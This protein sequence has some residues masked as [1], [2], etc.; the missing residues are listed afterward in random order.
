MKIL[1]AEDDI[2]LGEAI[3]AGLHYEGICVDWFKRGD[4]A[5]DALSLSD[6]DGFIL[7]IGLPGRNGLKV[8]ENLRRSG[9]HTP[10]LILTAMG[11]IEDRVNG[12]DQ[13]ADD[14]LVKPFD[15]DELLA[16]LRALT[17][18]SIGR[19]E[20]TIHYQDITITPAARRVEKS[21]QQIDLSRH[22][23]L[24][25]CRLIENRG[26]VYSQRALEETIHQW[27]EEIESNVIQVHI[28]HLRKKLGKSLIRTRRGIG[29]VID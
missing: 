7:D 13:G 27:N 23:Y 8:L 22:E 16:R 29:Y 15:M 25:L 26:H 24:I 14:Y 21:G 4:A 1:L 3:E 18:R 20:P 5:E 2:M 28:H 9:D 11:T 10:T 19:S 6:Y 12:L 17:R